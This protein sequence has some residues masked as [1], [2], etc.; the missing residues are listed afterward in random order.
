MTLFIIT[1]VAL[2]V[3]GIL[4]VIVQRGFLRKLISINIFTSGIFLIFISTTTRDDTADPI[5]TALVLT[6][7]VVTLGAS[8]FALM[9]IRSFA[10]E[11]KQESHND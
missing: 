2:F 5:V 10:R 4:G 3:L 8:A 11:S 1:G 7:L 9:L 6:G